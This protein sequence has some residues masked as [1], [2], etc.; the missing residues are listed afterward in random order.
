MNG[1]HDMGGLQGFGTIPLEAEESIFHAEWERRVFALDLA[2]GA[3]LSAS[4]DA[5]RHSIER[6]PPVDYL[7]A[8]YYERWLHAVIELSVAEGLLSHAELEQRC[9]ELRDEE[10]TCPS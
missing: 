10:A 1:I 7:K 9:R 2:M 5:W 3:Q 6:L 4:G 8:S